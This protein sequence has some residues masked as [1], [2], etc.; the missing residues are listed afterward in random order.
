M[1]PNE[2]DFELTLNGRPVRRR[3]RA[4]ELLVDFLR[5]EMGLSGTKFSCGVGSCGACK[6]SLQETHD[7]PR[8][9]LLACYARLGSINGLHVTTV[10]GLESPSGAL[11]PLQE[12]FLDEYSFQCGF[13]TPGFLMAGYVLLDQLARRPATEDIIDE[14]IHEAIGGNICRCTGYVRYFS[15]IRKVILATPGLVKSGSPEP[16]QTVIPTISFRVR[17]RSGNDLNEQTLIGFFDAPEGKAEFSGSLSLDTC[18]AW[19]SVSTSAIRTGEPV[20]DMNLRNFFFRAVKQIRFELSKAQ[21]LEKRYRID[22]VPR[23]TPVPV[24]IWG[25]LSLPFVSIPV[26]VDAV[27]SVLSA[28][29]LRLTS[30]AP[31]LLDMRDLGFGIQAF[32]KE[33]YLKLGNTVEIIIDTEL[34]YVI[35]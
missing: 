12:A 16:N 25:A 1:E 29:R 14:R 23:G 8:M 33:F 31:L 6:V 13:S 30:R 27:V 3:V 9:A 11:H 17:K 4:D 2:I 20:R 34:D 28:S 22:T 19:M 21:P 15:A 5:E 10:E 26:T 35:N 7:G 24:T 18:R 32:A